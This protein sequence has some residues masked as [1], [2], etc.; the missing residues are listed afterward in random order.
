MPFASGEK[1]RRL[2]AMLDTGGRLGRAAAWRLLLF[3]LAVQRL[4]V[5]LVV[6]ICLDIFNSDCC[7]FG[8]RCSWFGGLGFVVF[9]RKLVQI[10]LVFTVGA[11]A[12]DVRGG[13]DL[14]VAIEKN[15]HF[16]L[17]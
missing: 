10:G 3:P 6:T 9:R 15:T 16:G 1:D 4:Q 11:D 8:G 13:G 14:L 17:L 2:N 5:C 12:L 7:S